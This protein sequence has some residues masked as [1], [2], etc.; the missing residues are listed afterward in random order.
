LGRKI[1][2]RTTTRLL[3][4]VMRGDRRGSGETTHSIG[5]PQEFHRSSTGT[6]TLTICTPG[7]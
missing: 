7:T 2:R 1:R 6:G 5:V 4:Y 3:P